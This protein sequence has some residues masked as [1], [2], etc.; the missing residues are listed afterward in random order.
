MKLILRIGI[1]SSFPVGSGDVPSVLI[2]YY[3]SVS[4]HEH[5]SM[6]SVESFS[7]LASWGSQSSLADT[8]RVPSVDSFDE[9]CSATQ[10][11]VGKQSLSFKDYIQEQ[12]VPVGLG[13]P[14][15]PAA[16]LARF[17]GEFLRVA[18]GML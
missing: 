15:V 1:D 8:Q 17:T 9:D 13:K 5:S 12:K 7:G 4:L 18:Q 14:V 10:F 2:Q 6:D 11:C 3:L 16:V